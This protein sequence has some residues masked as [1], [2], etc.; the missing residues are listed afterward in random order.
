MVRA[1][2]CSTLSS[3]VGR[4]EYVWMVWL[5]WKSLLGMEGQATVKEKWFL[6]KSWVAVK[7]RDFPRESRCCC[8]QRVLEAWTTLRRHLCD[9]LAGH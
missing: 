5:P 3:I 2:T 4:W 7:K 6:W 8:R 9:L 1:F